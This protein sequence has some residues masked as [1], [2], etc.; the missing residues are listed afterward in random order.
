MIWMPPLCPH[1]CQEL[2]ET[3]HPSISVL[4]IGAKREVMVSSLFQYQGLI[5][6][7]VRSVKIHS[8]WKSLDLILYMWLSH[9]L[10][11]VHLAWADMVVS[12]PSS[13]WGRLRGRFDIAGSFASL[14]ARE[15]NKKQ[16]FLPGHIFWGM[17]KQSRKR[18]GVT[19]ALRYPFQ[20]ATV[21]GILK[22]APRL[23]LIDDIVTTGFTM[24]ALTSR[25]TDQHVRVLTFADAGI[26]LK[27]RA[28]F[29]EC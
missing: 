12:A 6:A 17:R 3:Q 21:Q 23:L 13:L 1:C 29:G 15:F 11:H 7:W 14:A 20:E 26:V 28:S 22:G 9:P 24:A 4:R 2:H 10:T 16:H 25:F 5:K 8:E 27:G 19:E 18:R